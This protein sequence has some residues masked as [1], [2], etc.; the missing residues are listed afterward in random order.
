VAA[1]L[2]DRAG[3]L[4]VVL[5]AYTVGYACWRIAADAPGL[6]ESLAN[7]HAY[8]IACALTLALVWLT[9]RSPALAP[10]VRRAWRLLGA[11]Y[12]SI[13]VGNLL[14]SLHAYGLLPDE[15][16]SHALW[17]ASGPLV[18][19]GILSFERPERTRSERLQLWIGAGSVVCGGAMLVVSLLV[20]PGARPAG[21]PGSLLTLAYPLGDL[22]LLLGAALL[23]LRRRDEPLRPVYLLLTATLLVGFT[24]DVAWGAMAIS[25]RPANV[26]YSDIAYM[27]AWALCGS[28]ALATLRTA[29][30]Q[31][32]REPVPGGPPTGVSLLPYGAVLL[33]YAT[34]LRGLD[35]ASPAALRFLV[36]G[37]TCL[38]ALALL[39]QWVTARE[40][41]RLQG[42]RAARRSEARFRTLVQSSSDVI[43]VV[44]AHDQLLYVAPSAAGILELPVAALAGQ[45]FAQLVHPDD[46]LRARLFLAHA[47]LSPGVAGPAELRVGKPG[48]WIAM[49]GLARNLLADPDIGG[50]V[51]TLRD[52]RERKVFE[53]QL[54][55]RALHDPLTGLANR[56]LFGD[57]LRHALEL[58]RRDGS[59]FAVLVADLDDFKA[60]NDNLGHATGDQVLV[61][62]ARRLRTA[63]RATDTASRLGGDELAVLLEGIDDEEVAE[64]TAER[65][66]A[67]VA[68]PFQAGAREVRLTASI[69][70]ALSGAEVSEDEVLRRA[71]LALYHAKESGKGRLAFF[72]P[73][74]RSE[75]LRRHGIE[76]ELRRAIHD[77]NLHLLYQPLVAL[78]SGRVVGA[79]ALV[80]WRHP[81]RGLVEPGDFIDLAESSGLI[82]PLGQWVIERA[83]RQAAAWNRAA[84]RPLVVGV[85]LSV[86]QLHDPGIVDQVRAALLASGLAPGQLVCEITETVLARD[87]LAATVRLRE[88]EAAG[89]RLA[90][91]DFGTGYSSLGRLRDLPIDILKI[92]GSFTRDLGTAQGRALA[93]AIVELAKAIDLL[94]VGEAVETAAQAA[95][96]AALR[97]D[98][99]QGFYFARPLEAEEL[100]GWLTAAPPVGA[101]VARPILASAPGE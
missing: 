50:L 37:A 5:I 46:R 11:A 16:G 97:C 54:M 99:G 101:L 20:L 25:G 32:A 78:R 61:E 87:P 70:A 77:G 30:A 100:S 92:D 74:M 73:G 33:G 12:V 7:R 21:E 17:L 22:V 63:V 48:R 72:A 56:A 58:S 43:A 59:R 62:A 14:S 4:W 86:R 28:A 90:L 68:E 83:C 24:A 69:G 67:A 55:H 13:A 76:G 64:A 3:R 27:L 29:H 8:S 31:P 81:T 26:A 34:L 89:V 53:E 84:A 39:N 45:P 15:R 57:R 49:E 18:L 85:N 41:V 93:G 10:P 23:A 79:E 52:V 44:D 60:I 66:L 88:L 82:E 6:G 42:E 98:L 94:V 47:A 95:A 1:L 96:L 40:N 71:D 2:A 65:I 19:A 91:D 80:R 51:L 9:V 75:M 38:T 35:V 36:G